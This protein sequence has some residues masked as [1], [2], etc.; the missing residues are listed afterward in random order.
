MKNKYHIAAIILLAITIIGDLIAYFFLPDTLVMQITFSKEAGT[1]M[2]TGLGLLIE[3]ALMGLLAYRTFTMPQ[4]QKFKQIAVMSILLI[5]NV[6]V[7]V[8][9]LK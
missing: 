2:P 9:N 6:I 8:F 7:L 1:T 4:E 5:F 3:C